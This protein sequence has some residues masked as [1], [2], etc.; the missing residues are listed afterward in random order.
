M[1]FPRQSVLLAGVATFALVL[2]AVPAYADPGQTV[3]DVAAAV[4]D[5]APVEIAPADLSPVGTGVVA[6]LDGGGQTHVSN[7]PAEGVQ[8]TSA[9]GDVVISFTLPAAGRLDDA[10]VADDGSVT[11]L[12]DT[13]APSVNV[14]AADDAIRVSTVIGAPHQTEVFPYDFGPGVTVEVEEDGSAIA[15]VL[16]EFVDPNTGERIVAQKII[17]DIT[18]PWAKDANGANVPTRYEAN[19]SV[20]TQIVD[21]ARGDYAYP[22]V[23]DPVFDRPNIFQYRVRFN[24]AETATIASGGAGVIASLGCGIML[25]VCLAAGGTI[26]WQAS[27]AQNSSPKR[28]VQ[29]TATQP[30]VVPGMYWWVDQYTGG[31]CR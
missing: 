30:Y 17:A 18:A 10:V 23:A 7:N 22:V 25:P 14:V 16:E 29:I 20:L 21:H 9:E 3:D 2:P 19:G 12:G 26:W 11:Y 13:T 8:V 31:P 4:A 24:R 6:S 1:K 27:V 5:V 28:C 15:Y